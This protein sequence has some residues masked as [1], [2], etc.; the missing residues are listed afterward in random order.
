MPVL[1]VAMVVFGGMGHI[2]GVVL[3]AVLLAALPEMLRYVVGP[4]QTLTDG[5]QV[6]IY[7]QTEVTR[8]LMAARQ[9]AG[10]VTLYEASAQLGGQIQLAQLLP[11]RSEFGGASTNLQREMALAG[12]RVVR[13]T[14]AGASCRMDARLVISGRINDVCAELDRLAELENRH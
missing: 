2:P 7:G 12:V 10:A 6:M 9:Q 5:K 3:G 13:N 1:I 4:L 11:R 8:D 14:D